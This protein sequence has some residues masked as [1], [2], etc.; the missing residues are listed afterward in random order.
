MIDG[1]VVIVGERERHWDW[2]HNLL[3]G[4]AG[5][6]GIFAIVE[7]ISQFVDQSS[8][9]LIPFFLLFFPLLT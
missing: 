2:E 7:A 5:E 3:L 1:L 8:Q 4:R 6:R 9:F